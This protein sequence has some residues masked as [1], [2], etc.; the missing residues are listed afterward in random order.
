MENEENWLDL[1]QFID[2]TTKKS[3]KKKAA[4]LPPLYPGN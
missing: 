2:N 3:S 4:E 1:Y